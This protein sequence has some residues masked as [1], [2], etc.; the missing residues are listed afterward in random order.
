MRHRVGIIGAGQ[1]GERHAVGVAS[2]DNAQVAAI[3]DVDSVRAAALARRFGALAYQDW[4]MM[5]DTPLDIVVVASPHHLHREPTEAAATRGIHVLVEKPLA[6]TP[7]DAK[8]MIAVCQASRVKLT[9]SFVHRF[10]QETQL[11]YGWLRQGEV[12]APQIAREVMSVQRSRHLPD[13]L[14]QKALAGG[15]VLMYSAIHGIDRLRWLLNSEV[16]QVTAQTHCYTPGAELEDGVV[17]LLKFAS[18]ATAT[19]T[20]NAPRYRVDPSFWETEI[21]GSQ[22][23]VRL[24][25]REWAE[26]SNDATVERVD[27]AQYDKQMPHYNFARQM[28][29]LIRA[30]TEDSEPTVTGI[31]GLK[32]L[33]LALAIYQSAASGRTITLEHCK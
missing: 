32:A 20:A 16:T 21:Y 30:I 17:A 27:T 9:V 24:R 8:R 2:L 23:M 26:L 15:G 12:G 11:L 19:L 3:A 5:L 25:T 1:A 18:G 7:A 22:G 13:W 14:Q 6:L 31:D 10:R 33:E 29:A 4:R 28:A